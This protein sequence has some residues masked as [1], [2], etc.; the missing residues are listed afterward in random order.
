MAHYFHYLQCEQRRDPSDTQRARLL[1]RPLGDARAKQRS[2]PF[3]AWH[4]RER[5]DAGAPAGYRGH[6]ASYGARRCYGQKQ[7]TPLYSGT[8][9]R[10]SLLASLP[11]VLVTR[12]LVTRVLVTRVLVTRVLVTR[13][14]QRTQISFI[15][16]WAPFTRP[17]P[18]LARIPGEGARTAAVRRRRPTRRFPAH[19]ESWAC[20]GPPLCCFLASGDSPPMA[21]P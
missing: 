10:R 18:P 20:G 21:S 13:G 11:R 4:Q 2:G 9:A 8:R 3:F 16:N 7:P 17:G 5:F 6:E 1:P 19:G 14:M 12:V 15:V